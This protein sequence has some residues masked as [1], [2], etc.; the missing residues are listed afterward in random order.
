MNSEVKEF[1][2]L[3]DMVQTID[4]GL[5]VLDRDFNVKL[6]NGFMENHSGIGPHE[7]KEKSL[8]SLFLRFFS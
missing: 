2:W 3:I 6:W 7:I 1:H 8:F 5:V 4:V